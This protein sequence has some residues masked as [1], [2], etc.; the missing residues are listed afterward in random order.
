MGPALNLWL[1]CQPV[2]GR[3]DEDA[4]RGALRRAALA[5]A[6]ALR[7]A[8]RS[9]VGMTSEIQSAADPAASAG[10]AAPASDT[11]H[12]SQS[13]ADPAAA[14]ARA[15]AALTPDGALPGAD[16]QPDH[17]SEGVVAFAIRTWARY[18]VPLT[19]VSAIAL[20]PLIVLAARVHPPADATAARPVIQLGWTLLAIAWLGQLLLVGGAAAMLTDPPSQLRAFTRGLVQLVRAVVPCGVAV[21]AIA[22]G[23]LA[24]LLPGLALL[25]LLSLTAAS[26]ERGL[27]APLLDSLAAARRQLPAVALAVLA[28]FAIDA[29]IGLIAYRGCLTP[30]P[31]K[32][33]PAQLAAIRDFVRAIALALVVLSPLP[34]TLLATLHARATRTRDREREAMRG[35]PS[36]RA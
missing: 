21:L 28:L 3:P 18:L 29:A 9:H 15:Q 13:A 32:P 16:P 1:A 17:R 30:L 4:P 24:L 25:V 27:P 2:R 10:A 6:I 19:L 8:P 14:G 11:T 23:S 5:P 35:Q 34:A 31:A 36:T 26:R 33:T 22:I 12:E 20:S 7:Q